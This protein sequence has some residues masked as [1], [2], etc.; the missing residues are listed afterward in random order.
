LDDGN[1]ESDSSDMNNSGF[2]SN[3]DSDNVNS[4]NGSSDENMSTEP[5]YIYINDSGSYT[6]LNSDIQNIINNANLGSTIEFLGS[7]YSNLHLNI[8][9]PLN[10]ISR[11]N[12]TLSSIYDMSIFTVNNGGSGTNISGFV[13]KSQGTFVTASDVSNIKISKNNISSG[14][15]AISLNKVYNSTIKQNIISDFKIG[16]DICNS[17]GITISKNNLSSSISSSNGIKLTDITDNGGIS[18]LKNNISKV[19]DGVYVGK[20]VANL[21]FESNNITKTTAGINFPNSLNNVTIKNN[22][23]SGNKNGVVVNGILTDFIFKSNTV[24][25][26]GE[27]GL[28]FG[29]NYK[30]SKGTFNV[31]SN[32]FKGNNKVDVE[33]SSSNNQRVTIG[34]NIASNLCPRV[35]MKYSYTLKTSSSNGKYY[36][37]FVDKNGNVASNLP[38][39]TTSISAGDGRSYEWEF[40]NGTA[41]SEYPFS[42][43]QSV[44]VTFTDSHHYGTLNEV[45][46]NLG[47]LTQTDDDTMAKNAKDYS[48]LKNQNQSDDDDD[49]LDIYQKLY[50]AS[51]QAKNSN[52]SNTNSQNSGSSTNGSSSSSHG[53]TASSTSSSSASLGTPSSSSESSSSSSSESSSGESV[54]SSSTTP[55]SSAEEEGTSLKTLNVDEESFRIIGV[56]GLLLLII[57]VISLYYR[58]DIQEMMKE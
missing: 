47:Q 25:N 20:N 34:E 57:L 16:L 41:Y 11:V 31:V 43:D 7:S 55:T 22:Y 49:D 23:F 44:S 1:N 13:V 54:D 26:S 24:L 21:V 36:A 30:G 52:S 4:D 27:S 58:E 8:N 17:G 14:G 6:S 3:V 46:S 29:D 32:Y 48:N 39:F 40:I 9:K 56:G 38:G 35:N 45:L 50:E 2:D 51:K 15:T 53:A 19:T 28:L 12:T 18:I 42:Q 37:T 33:S 10:I 5:Q